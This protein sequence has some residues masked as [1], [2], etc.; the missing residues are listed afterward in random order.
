MVNRYILELSTNNHSP[1]TV[2]E[3]RKTVL[4]WQR[5]DLSPVDYLANLKVKPSSRTKEGVILRGYLRWAVAHGYERENPLASIRFHAPP[6]PAIR[7]FSQAEID[8]LLAACR[9]PLETAVIICLLRLGLRAS[10]LVAITPSDLDGDTLLVR[11]KGGKSR[12]LAVTGL[13]GPLLAICEAGP[14]YQG[15]YRL[16]K[17]LGRRAGVTAWPHRCRHT[18]ADTYLRSGGDCNDLRVLLGHSSWVM[19]QRYTRYYEGERAIVAH[20]RFLEGR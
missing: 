20:R 3:Y 6:E 18:F 11:G 9:T 14:T 13:E 1:R 4:R 7:P 10:E 16:I 19:T 5:S 17:G 12:R 2:S 15:L 8:A